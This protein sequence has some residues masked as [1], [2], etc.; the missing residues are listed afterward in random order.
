MLVTIISK[1]LGFGR[2][3][4]LASYYG[5]SIYSDAYITAFNI[6]T[7]VFIP[8]ATAIG[9]AVT[10]LYFSIKAEKGESASLEYLNNTINLTLIISI[11]LILLVSI[12]PEVFVKTTAYGFEGEVLQLTVDYV[13]IMVWSIPFI[14]LANILT[15]YLQIKNKF[16][17][18]GL[19]GVPYNI[20]LIASI[21][22]STKYGYPILGFGSLLA[23]AGNFIFLYPFA[24]KEGYKYVF[25]MN[26]H[27][28]NIK[29]MIWLVSPVLIGVGVNQINGIVDRTMASTLAEGSISAL[30]YADRLT[31]LISGVLIVP[32]GSVIYPKL[33]EISSNKNVGQFNEIISRSINIVI[34]FLIP[35]TIGF[36]ILAEPIIK[37]LFERGSFDINATEMTKSALIFYSIGIIGF[38]LRDILGKIYYSLQDTRTPMI[39]GVIAMTLNIILNIILAQC[40]GHSGIA[41]ATSISSLITVILLIIN[42]K[43]KL[44]QLDFSK[45]KLFLFKSLVSA[46]VMGIFVSISYS[47]MVESLAAT[48]GGNFLSLILAVF[49]GIF[50]YF[51]LLKLLKADELNNISDIF[52]F[53]KR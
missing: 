48:I 35:I 39:N 31:S 49:I 14:G 42:L 13:R 34:M 52:K 30:N 10:P 26:I 27:D 44:K 32:I 47:F 43:V 4:V 28:E 15:S 41:F 5:T 1:I 20:I 45:I 7:L 3:V 22:L 17:I 11:L 8:F 21:I 16:S 9:I 53:S 46:I 38:G 2:E 50:V 33:S 19:I 24:R 25:R 36:I 51:G 40:M 37:V 23:L 29:K 6:P 12:F 18:T